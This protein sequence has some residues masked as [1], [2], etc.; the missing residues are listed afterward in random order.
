MAVWR[1]GRAFVAVPDPGPASTLDELVEVLRLLKTWAGDPSYE[2]IKDRINDAWRKAGRPEGELARRTTVADCFKAGRRRVNT[3]LVLAVVQ[4]LH[5]E[6]GYVTQWQQALRV[7][8]GEVAAAAQ[9]RVQDCLPRGLAEFT[10]RHAELDRLRRALRHGFSDGGTVVISAIEGMAGVGKTQLAIHAGHLITQEHHCDR[11]LFV[12]LRGFHPDP[13]QPPADPAA[14]L[15]GFLRLL[16]VPGQQIPHALKARETLYR[17]TLAGSRTLIVLDNAA[18]S[19]QVRPLLP[20]TAG[21]PVLVTS[22]RSLTGL[23]R[24]T[25]VAVDVFTPDE[26]LEFLKAAAPEVGIGTDPTAPA[27]IAH[28]CGGLPLALGLVAAHIRTTTGWTLT[29]HADRLDERHAA[30]RLDSAVELALDLSYQHLG[31]TQQRLLR[32]AASHPGQDLDAYAAAALSGVDLRSAQA[33]LQALCRNHLLQRSTPGRYLLHDLVRSYA[34]TRG[35]DEDSLSE[36]RAALTRLFDYYLATT[37]AAMDGMYPAEAHRRPSVAVAADPAPVV[38][39]P[40][41]ARRWLDV[42]RAS[43]VAV[44]AYTAA[45]GWPTHTTRLAECL[46]RYLNGGYHTD[47]HAV[48]SHAVH[49]AA[50]LGDPATHAQALT[51]LGVV[52]MWTGRYEL[53]ARHFEQALPLF[54]RA[55]HPAGQARALANLGVLSERLGRYLPALDY[56]GLALPLNQQIGDLVA[57]ASTLANICVIKVRLG[58]HLEA[59][60]LL[61]QALALCRQVGDRIGEAAALNVLG[62]AESKLGRNQPAADHLRQ[63]LTLYRQLGDQNGEAATLDSLGLFH[64]GLGRPAEATEHYRQALAIVREMNDPQGEACALNGL[65]EAAHA[66]GSAVEAVR[67]H[68]E[69]YAISADIGDRDQQARAHT[70]LGRSHHT[71]GALIPARDHYRRALALHTELGS[72]PEI[73]QIGVQLARIDRR[74][75]ELA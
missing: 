27:R 24:A 7:I 54:R 70:G 13:A 58:Q 56:Y 64:V 33:G 11:V 65:G 74:L 30:R 57:Q 37:A 25:H 32:L 15:D 62:H 10:G 43:L 29:D 5:P 53:S 66:A 31:A 50:Q 18:D 51:N 23:P 14:V 72:Q 4:A 20:E 26:A 38:A 45:Q 61:E 47:A 63:A 44:A 41:S 6:T 16:G 49:A 36:R 75:V 60:E 1:S 9:V 68:A 28:R 73:D 52:F 46:F 55:D 22:R 40:E 35:A 17:E 39:D 19:D 69:A 34:V 8:G 42:E 67:H 71:L 2:M 12:N 59:V 21:C 48:H 3:E